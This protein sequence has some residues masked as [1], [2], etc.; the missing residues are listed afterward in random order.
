MEAVNDKTESSM[1][2]RRI[3]FLG[4][5]RRV[6]VEEQ[7]FRGVRRFA[8]V[9]GWRVEESHLPGLSQDGLAALL[10][11]LR[12]SGCIVE[13]SGSDGFPP[14]RLFG[15]VPAVWLDIPPDAAGTVARRGVMVDNAA[16]AE[17]AFREL[18]TTRPAA[19]AAIS[20]HDLPWAAARIRAFCALAQ[21]RGHKCD[22][23][24]TRP[25]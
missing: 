25:G 12:P 4:K 3:L 9:L 15:R 1:V 11:T 23:F 18:A 19:F 21:S 6:P 5:Q 13:C 14:P 8:G 2:E 20:A 16:V 24:F 17:A 10:R 22:A 7:K